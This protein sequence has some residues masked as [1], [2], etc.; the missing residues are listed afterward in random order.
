MSQNQFHDCCCRSCVFEGHLC[1]HTHTHRH[2][3]AC[4]DETLTNKVFVSV[5]LC[6]CALQERLNACLCQDFSGMLAPGQTLVNANKVKGAEKL[7]FDSRT[8][9][10]PAIKYSSCKD[11]APHCTCQESATEKYDAVRGKLK[12]PA[13]T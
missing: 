7:V 5:S 6:E 10:E 2:V 13:V 3:Y 12:L 11:I 9:E 8:K 1:T 4:L